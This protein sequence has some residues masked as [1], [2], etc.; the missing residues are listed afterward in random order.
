MAK[1]VKN[2]DIK[3]FVEKVEK[4]LAHLKSADAQELTENLED[5]LRER[6]ADEGE[7]FVLPNANSY[8]NELV[9]AAGL[10]GVTAETSKISGYL[11]PAAR[12]LAKYFVS[13]GPAWAV[14]RGYLIY[15]V[16]YG[17]AF[18][19]GIREVPETNL[20]TLVLLASIGISI[21]LN[22]KKYRILSVA[23]ICLNA[24]VI[25]LLAP[26]FASNIQDKVNDYRYYV[27]TRNIENTIIDANGNL[28][29]TACAYDD[30]GNRLGMATLTDPAGSTILRIPKNFSGMSCP[31]SKR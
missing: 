14:V 3:S 5:A 6:R 27:Q 11:I 7:S 18:Y 31:T 29:T 4:S 9:E 21:W 22:L 16:G 1:Q 19:G 10:S 25:L 13:F 17:F 20:D 2:Q 26:V 15:A 12:K 28:F 8:A 23:G 24:V 30:F